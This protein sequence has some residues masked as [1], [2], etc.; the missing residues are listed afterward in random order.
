MSD[1]IKLRKKGVKRGDWAKL[2][3]N[4]IYLS[5]SSFSV[6]LDSAVFSE[7]YNQTAILGGN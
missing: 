4:S 5:L 3:L 6:L 2:L 7:H 1:T